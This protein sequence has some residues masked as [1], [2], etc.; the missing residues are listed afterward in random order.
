MLNSLSF[1]HI[2]LL[3]PSIED[4]LEYYGVLF[5]RDNISKS[6]FVSSQSVNVCFIKIGEQSYIELISP[7][8]AESVVVKLLKKGVRYYHIGYRV[9]N[10]EKVVKELEYLDFKSLEYFQSEAFSNRRCIFLFSP[11]TSLIELI[12]DI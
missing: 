12:E 5:G 8:G 4:A 9:K 1:H 7:V 10:I 6:I 3:V 2:G 11:D